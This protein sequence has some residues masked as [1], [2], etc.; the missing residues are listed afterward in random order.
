MT[1]SP[2]GEDPLVRL[3]R[4]RRLFTPEL[5]ASNDFY[6]HAHLL[7]RYAGL[8]EESPLKVAI[9]HGVTLEDSIWKV[10]LETVMSVFLC[11]GAAHARDYEART[12][13]RKRAL[14]IGPMYRYAEAGAGPAA[15]RTDR[16]LLAFPV[17]SSHRVRAVFDAQAFS[18]EAER[19]GRDFDRVVVCVYWRDVLH[20]V[21][22]LF[23]ARGFEVVSAGHMFD[24]EFLPRLVR[25]VREATL[26]LTNEV[27]TQVLVSTLM[28][29][30]VLLRRTEVSYEA[31]GAVLAEDVPPFLTHPRVQRILELF[32][33][34]HDAPTAAQR[35]LVEEVA[36]AAHTRSPT[37]MRTILEEAEQVYRRRVG[38]A[39]RLGDAARRALFLIR[40][41]SRDL[42]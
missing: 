16:V 15:P 20:G 11:A 10:D 5:H 12:G 31:S 17:H 1:T 22:E 3:C 2:P 40:R 25:I 18:D 28:G 23:R 9:E 24:F 42:L 29:K 19:V 21:H 26:V 39:R 32:S 13:G 33:E 35:A 30:P 41:T 6:G 7:K 4:E 37:E 8:R 27:G 38:P 14:P 34:P 36:G